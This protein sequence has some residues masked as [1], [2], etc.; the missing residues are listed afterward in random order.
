ME[1]D[2]S[3]VGPVGGVDV[4]DLEKEQLSSGAAEVASSIKYLLSPHL[5]PFTRS[6]SLQWKL[7]ESS[8]GCVRYPGVYRRG[9]PP[10]CLSLGT[11]R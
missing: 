11:R 10:L 1:G 9:L 4:A 3:G 7:R 2:D 6:E 5:R 8:E